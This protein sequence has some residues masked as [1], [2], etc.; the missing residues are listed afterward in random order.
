MKKSLV[1]LVAV[2]M[3]ICFTKNIF[4]AENTFNIG[5]DH[6]SSS[7][8]EVMGNHWLHTYMTGDILKL[9]YLADYYKVE[10]NYAN[11]D[12]GF[13]DGKVALTE[14]IGGYKVFD[15][16]FIILN[17]YK[18][19]SSTYDDAITGY[20]A[21]I[22]GTYHLKNNMSIKGFVEVSLPYEA[23]KWGIPVNIL[24]DIWGFRCNIFDYGFQFSQS[25]TD[26]VNIHF[27]FRS[28]KATVNL[29]SYYI[30]TMSSLGVTYSF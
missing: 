17:M 29:D 12:T 11:L 26:K 14:I 6:L 30:G 1:I 24:A 15:G 18:Q 27:S 23:R 16:V 10:L 13:I 28:L 7:T 3:L 20:L 4:A 25:I 19:N 8:A 21:G 9:E 22:D 5:F 2:L